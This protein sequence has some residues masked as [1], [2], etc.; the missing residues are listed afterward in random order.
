MLSSRLCLATAVTN[1]LPTGLQRERGVGVV[2]LIGQSNTLWFVWN[3]T[4]CQLAMLVCY[5]FFLFVFFWRSF[6]IEQDYSARKK[7]SDSP[8]VCCRTFKMH[9][10]S[11][12]KCS[13]CQCSRPQSTCCP[14]QIVVFVFFLF[15][16]FCLVQQLNTYGI[17]SDYA[18]KAPERQRPAR[19]NLNV[20]FMSDRTG[21]RETKGQRRGSPLLSWCRAGPSSA[22]TLSTRR[23]WLMLLAVESTGIQGLCERAYDEKQFEKQKR[24]K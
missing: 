24:A 13:F 14:H 15:F 10:S 6:L 11:V 1:F 4:V 19:I 21:R 3:T 9:H 12:L 22:S 2:A 8:W 17:K 5:C 23:D 20:E 7:F 16:V 18:Q